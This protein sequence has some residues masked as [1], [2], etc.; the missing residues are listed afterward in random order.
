MTNS[1]GGCIA[2]EERKQP[3]CSFTHGRSY[4]QPLSIHLHGRRCSTS[5]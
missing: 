4:S 1:S 3:R 2:G 5:R